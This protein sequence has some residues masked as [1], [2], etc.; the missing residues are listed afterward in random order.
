[1]VN[2]LFLSTMISFIAPYHAH[3]SRN[4]LL[5]VTSSTGLI[6]VLCSSPIGICSS[7][8]VLRISISQCYVTSR[9]ITHF[10]DSFYTRWPGSCFRSID[11][12]CVVIPRGSSLIS[13]LLLYPVRRVCSSVSAD[14]VQVL[15]S[16]VYLADLTSL[17]YTS[18][19]CN[20]GSPTL[21]PPLAYKS[22]SQGLPASFMILHVLLT[23]TQSSPAL[24]SIDITFLP[25]YPEF[26]CLVCHL[27]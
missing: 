20:Q 18:Y 13:L 25:L 22:L 11:R 7:W 10:T 9:I 2:F 17:P 12:R 23:C 4:S 1:M 21:F 27:L 15:V 26:T 6:Q 5:C 16:D 14:G 8:W 19:L 3:S 24:Y